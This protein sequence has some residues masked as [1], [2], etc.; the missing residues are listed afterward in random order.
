MSA[1]DG[2]VLAAG[3][4]DGFHLGHR[5]VF[6]SLSSSARALHLRAAAFTFRNHPRSVLSPQSAPL[7]LSTP[8]ERAAAMRAAGAEDIAMEE[9]TP[10]L[11]AMPPDAFIA[12]LRRRFGPIRRVFCGGDWRFGA[13]AAGNA[14]TLRDAGIDTVEVPSADYAGARVSSTRIREAIRSGDL[15]AAAGMLS[16]PFSVSGTVASGKGA[17]RSIGFPTVN[18]IPYEGMC[19]P[20]CGV[21]ASENAVAN[22]GIAPTFGKD[23]W[24]RPVLEVHMLDSSPLPPGPGARI[25]VPLLRFIRPEMRFPD[26][27]SLAAQIA[28]DVEICRRG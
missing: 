5:R 22:L 14:Q 10:A 26:V 7:L 15:A 27:A 13:K 28:E 2:C 25:S 19:L 18:I 21:Y 12:F 11:A 9:F 4:F 17:G 1:D 20:P 8:E 24:Q 16:R 6:E 3:F 23:A